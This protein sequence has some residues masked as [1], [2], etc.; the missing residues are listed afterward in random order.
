VS[1][2]DRENGVALVLVL[3]L[4]ALVSA[5]AVESA[6]EDWISLHRAENMKLASQAMLAAESGLE[7]GRKVLQEDDAGVDSLDEDWARETPPL[8]LD[9]GDVSGRI[10]DTGRFFNLDDLVDDHGAAQKEAVAIARRL[11]SR[12]KLDP[13]LVDTLVD[14]MD[15]DDT[16]YG[17]G[18]AEDFAYMDKRW[19]VKNAPLDSLEEILLVRGFD[20]DKL[21]R[22]RRVAVARPHRGITPVN[23][24]TAEKDVL[25]SLADDIPES[26]VDEM[27]SQRKDKPWRTVAAWSSQT[28]YS[29]WA[30]R[31]NT[32]R[33]G[34]VSDAFIIRSE[35]R[36]GRARWGEEM[37]VDRSGK[38]LRVLGRRKLAELQP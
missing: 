20:R 2:A 38:T 4:V 23:I 18:G 9:G 24:N 32:A 1:Q 6:S 30:G 16:P 14:W 21:N 19:R 36:F 22:L 37:L 29:A 33:L 15:K 31:I 34:T 35:A 27:L 28:P 8:P 13:A 10:V 11:F 7:L 25:M 26:D 17:P 12:L 3:G 5:W